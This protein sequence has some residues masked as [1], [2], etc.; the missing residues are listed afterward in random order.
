[1]QNSSWPPTIMAMKKPIALIA[2]I[3]RETNE[4]HTKKAQLGNYA[5]LLYAIYI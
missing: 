4:I 2:M 5:Q 1:M 3:A